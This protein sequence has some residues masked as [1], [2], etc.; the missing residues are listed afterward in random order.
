[1]GRV[2]V[3]VVPEVHCWLGRKLCQTDAWISLAEL[4]ALAGERLEWLVSL[5]LL[6]LL[7]KKQQLE[8]YA[9]TLKDDWRLEE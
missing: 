9:S 8:C 1:M 3:A 6:A 5:F 2:Q 4:A 7:E